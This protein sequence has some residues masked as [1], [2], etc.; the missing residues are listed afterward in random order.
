MAR[1]C[2]KRPKGLGNQ[3]RARLTDKAISRQARRCKTAGGAS[4][5]SNNGGAAPRFER[6]GLFTQPGRRRPHSV[7][8]VTA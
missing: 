8:A 3:N 4:G 1:E 7:E 2:A 5:K 6:G